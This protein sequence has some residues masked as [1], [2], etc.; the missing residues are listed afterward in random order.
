MHQNK[1]K[2]TSSGSLA[3]RTVIVCL[4]FLILPLFIHTFFLYEHEIE[5]AENEARGCLKAIG[6]EVA[7]RISEKVSKNP[8]GFSS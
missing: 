2:I 4:I 5:M 6:G 7:K 1:K 8:K 3:R